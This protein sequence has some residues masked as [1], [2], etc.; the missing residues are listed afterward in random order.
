T[1]NRAAVLG[2]EV[3]IWINLLLIV[4]ALYKVLTK[5]ADIAHVGKAI[6]VYLPVYAVWA[7]IVTF[8]FPLMFGFK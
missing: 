6:A 3:L 8:L 2:G 7:V 1:P 5:K 4:S